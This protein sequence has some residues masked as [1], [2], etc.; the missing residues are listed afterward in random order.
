MVT[1][2]KSKRKITDIDVV[3]EQELREAALHIQP[4]LENEIAR[5][6]DSYAAMYPEWL[7]S[8][9]QLYFNKAFCGFALIMYGFGSKKALIEDFASK[10]LTEYSV[11]VVNGYLQTI[12]LKQ[13]R[14]F[15]GGEGY[16]GIGY[17]GSRDRG[18]GGSGGGGSYSRGRGGGGGKWRN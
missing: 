2:K 10:T 17:G 12:N 6:M 7:L 3:D 13:H 5:L 1:V 8:L 11:I 4:K 15:G 14:A 16:G 18:Y 9:R